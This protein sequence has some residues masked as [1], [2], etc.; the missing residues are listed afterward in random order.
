[1]VRRW[2]ACF[3]VYWN[4]LLLAMNSLRLSYRPSLLAARFS[5][6]P[7]G[8]RLTTHY[9]WSG[10]FLHNF[11]AISAWDRKFYPFYPIFR[12]VLQPLQSP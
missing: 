10:Y 5:F 3:T 8:D 7:E 1:M 6:Y 2:K 11:C 4:V 12:G 9:Y